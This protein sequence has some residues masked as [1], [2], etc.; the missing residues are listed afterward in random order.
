MLNKNKF[1][2]CLTVL[3]TIQLIIAT[4]QDKQFDLNDE[5]ME[6]IPDSRMVNFFFLFSLQIHLNIFFY[7]PLHNMFQDFWKNIKILPN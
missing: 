6:Y 1:I 3:L 2:V 5:I 4:E 7:R